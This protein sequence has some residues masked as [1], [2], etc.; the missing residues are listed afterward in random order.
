MLSLCNNFGIDLDW[1]FW[2]DDDD[3]D[4]NNFHI[5]GYWILKIL[6]IV[7]KFVPYRWG[8]SLLYHLFFCSLAFFLRF[9]VHLALLLFIYSYFQSMSSLGSCMCLDCGCGCCYLLSRFILCSCVRLLSQSMVELIK[10]T[11]HVEK[12]MM[13]KYAVQETHC[14]SHRNYVCLRVC[15]TV[16]LC[17]CFCCWS[18]LNGAAHISIDL[19]VC[20]F[21]VDLLYLSFPHEIGRWYFRLMESA[22]KINRFSCQ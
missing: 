1:W 3:D 15:L 7:E 5:S 4:N 22:P 2:I 13:Q 10:R 18:F 6:A 21:F 20:S 19:L 8:P 11:S 12:C 16:C 17:F 14:E 9:L